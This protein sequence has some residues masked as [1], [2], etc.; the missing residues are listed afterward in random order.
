M[1][2]RRTLLGLM[3][4]TALLALPGGA[5]ATTPSSSLTVV[6]QGFQKGV[7]TSSPAGIVCGAQCSAQFDQTCTDPTNTATCSPTPVTLNT[8]LPTG[9]SVSWQGATC[10]GSGETQTGTACTVPADDETVTARYIDSTAPAISLT[11]PSTT[12]PFSGQIQ[13][14]A[15]AFD[16]QSGISRVDFTVGQ[17]VVGTATTSPYSVNFDTTTIP[18]GQVSIGAVAYNGD[19][20]AQT[21]NPRPIQIDNT[22]PEVQ[23][24][25]GPDGQTFGGGSTQVF[26]FTA[27]DADGVTTACSLDDDKNYSSCADSA[28]YTNE[29]EGEHVFR[30]R[31]VDGAGNETDLSRKFTIDATGPTTTIT[32]G[33]ADFS[34]GTVGRVSFGFTSSEDGSSFACRLYPS[35]TMPPPDFV[36]CTT[37]GTETADGLTPGDWT[38][39]VFAIDAYGNLGASVTRHFSVVFAGGSDSVDASL[40]SRFA[41]KG[42]ATVVRLL[43]VRN[44]VP[45]TQVTISCHGRSCRFT[46]RTVRARDGAAI[47][48]RFFRRRAMRPGTTIELQ[49]TAP[50]LAG[51]AFRFRT[52]NNRQPL[53]TR[54]PLRAAT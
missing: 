12:G 42:A 32:D 3:L 53:L 17:T 40:A 54:L 13:L 15:S 20:Q 2:L 23:I 24:T 21:A 8:T 11:S 46:K 45:G 34:S 38:F 29:P 39:E 18:D 44:L 22:P 31:A 33:P 50:G 9:F 52:R 35:A 28:T 48:E 1:A 19:G 26:T 25:S 51:Q 30:I 7:V 37:N 6:K 47:L 5:Y 4:A 27:N 41:V 49:V 36:P 14:A 10:Q 16:S 43:R